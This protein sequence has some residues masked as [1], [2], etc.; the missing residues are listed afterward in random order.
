MVTRRPA[1]DWPDFTE[2]ARLQFWSLPEEVIEAFAEVF[3]AFTDHPQRP[4]QGLDVGPMRNDRS[5]WR[6]KVD[7]YRALY[8]LRH[9]RP[10]IERILPRTDATY[11]LFGRVP[12]ARRP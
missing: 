12:T 4:S 2:T 5:R 3:P 6:L 1:D 9:G 10:L 11:Q 8:S 7:G